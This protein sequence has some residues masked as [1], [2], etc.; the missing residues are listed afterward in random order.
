[1][2]LESITLTGDRCLVVPEELKRSEN[3]EPKIGTDTRFRAMKTEDVSVDAISLR[4]GI[5][6][7]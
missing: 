1:M 4:L 5:A 7:A 3:T 6:G 2:S